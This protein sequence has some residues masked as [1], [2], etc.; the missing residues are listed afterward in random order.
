MSNYRSTPGGENYKLGPERGNV[1][2][3]SAQM[4]WCFSLESFA[5]MY[6]DTYGKYGSMVFGECSILASKTP[7]NRWI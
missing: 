3:A 7:Y 5:K 4:G 1:C 6:A 2:F